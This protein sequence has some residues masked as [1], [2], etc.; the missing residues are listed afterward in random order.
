MARNQKLKKK[1]GY[2]EID[3]MDNLCYVTVAV[4][5]KEYT[6]K[7]LHDSVNKKQKALRKRAQDFSFQDFEE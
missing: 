3:I 5:S 7:F 1:L 2:Y 4:N 6:E